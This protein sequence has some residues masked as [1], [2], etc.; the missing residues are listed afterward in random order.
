MSGFFGSGSGGPGGDVENPMVAPLDADYQDVQNPNL[1]GYSEDVYTNASV[2]GTLD[3]DVSLFNVFMLTLTGDATLNLINPPAA[4]LVA[5]TIVLIQDGTGGHTPTFDGEDSATVDGSVEW[6]N[7]TAPTL[8]ET[9]GVRHTLSFYT[10]DGNGIWY[11]AV[12]PS[13]YNLTP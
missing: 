10:I 4:G 3:L 6:P 5:A 1:K 2:S 13:N 11:G 12:G 9:A 7:E 8:D